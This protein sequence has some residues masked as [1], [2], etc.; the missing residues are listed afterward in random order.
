MSDRI[1]QFINETLRAAPEGMQFEV[2]E[3]AVA[4]K[5]GHPIARG[6]LRNLL[7]RN[8]NLFVEDKGGRWRLRIHAE[9]VEPEDG[10]PVAGQPMRQPLRRGRFVVFDLETLGREADGEDIEIIEIAFARYEEGSQVEAWQTFVRPSASIPKLI[11]ELTTITDDDVSAAPG[12][13]EALKEFFRRTAG[14]PLIAHNGFAFDGV[15]LGNVASRVGVEIPADL[16][17]LDT[18]PLARLFLQADGQ[19]YSLSAYAR[20]SEHF[21]VLRGKSTHEK[22]KKYFDS[23]VGGDYLSVVERQ[24]GDGRTY[25]AV[26][27]TERGRDVLAGAVP[28]PGNGEPV[29]V[30]DAT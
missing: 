23:L 18:L 2:L 5:L 16:L 17:I 4:V 20:N 15:V 25:K 9:A 8:S 6:S 28:A 22:L 1:I 27:L 29:T 30:E 12:Q 21:G 11:T 3:R 24:H 19:R 7:V 26:R 13:R 14:Y 10:E